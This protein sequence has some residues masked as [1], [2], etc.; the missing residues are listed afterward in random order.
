MGL[1]GAAILSRWLAELS[2]RLE[3]SSQYADEPLADFRAVN[4]P[5]RRQADLPTIVVLLVLW[6]VLPWSGS[7]C[8][9]AVQGIA[10][11]RNPRHVW[12]R[13]FPPRWGSLVFSRGS[14]SLGHSRV[15]PTSLPRSARLK[16]D[17]PEEAGWNGLCWVPQIPAP[18]LLLDSSHPF[19]RR[20]CL[21]VAD[22]QGAI[23]G[24]P[25][26]DESRERAVHV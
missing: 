23:P 25:T 19:A 24:A 13:L 22:V 2:S 4:R 9:K 21:E 10:T 3:D 8:R 7:C 26:T 17:A 5:V 6:Y 15:G 1:L 12:T 14:V 18:R 11:R 16:F 20:W